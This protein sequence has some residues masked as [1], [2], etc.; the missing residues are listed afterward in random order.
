MLEIFDGFV[1]INQ[2]PNDN[3]VNSKLSIKIHLKI[4]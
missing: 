3:E 4:R 1:A 2:L